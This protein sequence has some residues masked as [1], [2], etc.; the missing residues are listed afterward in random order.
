M[1][2]TTVSKPTGTPYTNVNAQ[3][4]EQYDQA[5]LTYD[6]SSIFYDGI[7]QTIWT[8]IDKPTGESSDFITADMATGL[9]IPLTYSTKHSVEASAWI[10]IDKPT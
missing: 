1:T 8:G 2:W 7:N 4:K 3:G 10:K 6:D 5:S 9:L